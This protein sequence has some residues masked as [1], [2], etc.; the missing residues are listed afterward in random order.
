MVR[1]AIAN[2][3]SYKVGPELRAAGV[4]G[5]P[6]LDRISEEVEKEIAKLS[7]GRTSSSKVEGGG[8]TDGGK[9]RGGNGK[10]YNELPA[11]AKAACDSFEK[12]LVGPNKLHKT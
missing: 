10:G 9:P 3:V 7:G 5:R 1:T 12:Q 8:P 2:A 11:E 4:I 6:Y